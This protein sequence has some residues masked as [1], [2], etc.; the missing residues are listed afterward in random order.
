[1]ESEK[2]CCQFSFLPP[3][4]SVCVTRAQDSLSL[5][6]AALVSYNIDVYSLSG[7]IMLKKFRNPFKSKLFIFDFGGEITNG[8]G[9]VYPPVQ[10][11][12]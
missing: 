10:P 4:P 3:L 6:D 9:N 12:K 11:I 7:L 5:S 8:D 1:M 2:K